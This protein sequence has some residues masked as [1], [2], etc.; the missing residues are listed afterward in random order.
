[1]GRVT[2]C[3]ATEGERD[4]DTGKLKARGAAAFLVLLA[5]AGAV[6][7]GGAGAT[8]RSPAAEDRG[9]APGRV[10]R[11]LVVTL[12]AVAWKDV[13]D[14]EA[15]LPNLMR[16]LDGSRL[17]DL[18]TRTPGRRPD[19]TS[20]YVI[21]GA[22]ARADRPH[23][24]PGLLFGVSEP[25]T[26]GAATTGGE[27]FARRTGHR[28]PPGSVVDLSVASLRDRN[29]S[30]LYGAR[31]GALGEA[32]AEAGIHRA[33]VANAD[34][35]GPA[36]TT[37]LDVYRRDAARALTG[38]DGVVPGGRVDGGLLRADPA[39]PF[40]VRYDLAAVTRAFGR[41][42]GSR[43][44]GRRAV[45]L[46]EASD[47]ARADS[48][49]PFVTGPRRELFKK[50]ALRWTDELVGA[51]LRRVDPDRDAVVLATPAVAKARGGLG[52]A[53]V[54]APWTEPGLLESATTRRSGFAQLTDVAPTILDLFGLPI[55]D[56]MEGRP[57]E[58]GRR[59]GADAAS[60]IDFLVDQ[61][62]AGL[63]RDRML[64][65]VSTVYVL[66]IVVMSLGTV[67]ALQRRRRWAFRILQWLALWMLGVMT[68]TWLAGLVPLH[69]SGPSAY[70]AFL[71][72]TGA[73]IAVLAMGVGR[74]VWFDPV[75]AVLAAVVVVFL[76]DVLTGSNLQWN[77]AFGHSP[78]VAGR[79]YGIDNST[80]AFVSACAVLLAGLL[81]HR[82]G[83]RRG[84]WAGTGVLVAL[85]AVDGLPFWGAD[86]GGILAL[87]PTV[88]VT[89][90]MLLGYR[91]RVRRVVG[92]L[93]AALAAFVAVGFLDLARPA[94]ERTHLGRLFEKLVD[95]DLNGVTDVIRRKLDLLL[96]TINQSVWT[97]MLPV[98]FL[99]LAYLV[100]RAPGRL[101][102]LQDRIPELRAALAG[103]LV[104]GVLG[105]ALND[106][107][108]SI[109]A[110][111]LG[112]LDGV[113]V[114]LLAREWLVFGD[115]PL[116]D[117]PAPTPAPTPV[118]APV[119]G[120][121]R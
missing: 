98:V 105:F 93:V 91:V 104:V 40:G 120:V 31:V 116:L 85:L 29:A 66:S 61:E 47:L 89:G 20:G 50:W 63:F 87:V 48:Y 17:A 35:P 96:A 114:F 118:P 71:A 21:L 49:R 7:A 12:P 69:R 103:L 27:L 39:A 77:T 56:E 78:T 70:W 102:T 97:L 65:Q 2:P 62:A 88:L 75:M 67:A 33:V 28:A 53:A 16:L 9:A 19:R 41:A 3:V 106:S 115:D 46:V 57:F 24:P 99:F 76:G 32:L 25:L 52:M 54:R 110:I 13:A 83:G 112:V 1:M 108:I 4:I 80:F 8:T 26:V 86:A 23:G 22:G 45:V 36:A 38:A 107:G 59:G 5:A 51:L 101:R 81:A 73:A 58:P 92:A 95:G 10:R 113:L 79:F 18:S 30:L 6:A 121:E 111:M 117:A 43:D 44:G 84:A 11:V 72:A 15:E 60:R 14:H 64:P 90:S 74:R 42:W 34:E 82:L 55:P 68:A 94:D 109:P 100:Y 37:G 119:P